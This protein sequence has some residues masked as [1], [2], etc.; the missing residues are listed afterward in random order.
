MSDS[1]GFGFVVRGDGPCY[2]QTIDPT[3]PAASAGLKV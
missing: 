2:I 3:G 1:V